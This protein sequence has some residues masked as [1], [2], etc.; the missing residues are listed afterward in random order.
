MAEFNTVE[1]LNK[2]NNHNYNTCK[3]YSKSYLQGNDLREIIDESEIIP[4]KEEDVEMQ[5]W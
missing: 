2:L 1:I 4:P 5:K 3:T